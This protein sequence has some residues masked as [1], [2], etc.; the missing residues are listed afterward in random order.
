MHLAAK[1]STLIA[2]PEAPGWAMFL[3]ALV[4]IVL[5]ARQRSASRS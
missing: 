5:V 3:V 4:V 1:L 2:V